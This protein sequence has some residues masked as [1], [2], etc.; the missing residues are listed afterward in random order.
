MYRII[1]DEYGAP[2][3]SCLTRTDLQG[4]NFT[5]RNK[6]ETVEEHSI[7]GCHTPNTPVRDVL[8]L[9]QNISNSKTS[10]DGSL[11]NDINRKIRNELRNSYTQ[12]DFYGDDSNNDNNSLCQK[13]VPI[14]ATSTLRT[15]DREQGRDED[16]PKED[17]KNNELKRKKENRNEEDRDHYDNVIENNILDHRYASTSISPAPA[18][19][20]PAYGIADDHMSATENPTENILFS[21]SCSVSMK[22][23]FQSAKRRASSN[24]TYNSNMYGLY[25]NSNLISPEIVVR[26]MSSSYWRKKLSSPSSNTMNLTRRSDYI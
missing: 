15:R 26:S 3:L 1:L 24:S 17:K 12:T 7:D 18:Y 10:E 16:D 20:M 2:V 22:K 23:L 21:P 25:S 9:G 14:H 13:S 19:K 5:D 11:G 6:N 4:I 8:V